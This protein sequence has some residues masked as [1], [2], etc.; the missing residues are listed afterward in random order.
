MFP[1]C[2]WPGMSFWM[3]V[4]RSHGVG[5]VDFGFQGFPVASLYAWIMALSDRWPKLWN[6]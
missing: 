1:T 3:R 6:A 5:V 4:K 2:A